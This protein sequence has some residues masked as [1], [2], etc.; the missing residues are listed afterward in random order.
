MGVQYS[1]TR[2]KIALKSPFP[3]VFEYLIP[4]FSRISLVLRQVASQIY[5]IVL[6]G[7][8]VLLGTAD[9]LIIV[10]T[11]IAT[12]QPQIIAQARIPGGLR[13]LALMNDV[14]LATTAEFWGNGR[15]LA[16]DLQ[17]LTQ[18]RLIGATSLP[19]SKAELAAT[20]EGTILV[21]NAAMG[22]MVFEAS[23]E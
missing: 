8:V 15:L 3:G 17:D 5:D 13:E 11:D 7:D 22:L 2:T 18:P 20:D 9:G 23:H 1:K 19:T 4:L 16:I 21:G 6:D 14:L 12:G 10:S